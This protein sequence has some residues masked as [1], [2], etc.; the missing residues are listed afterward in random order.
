MMGAVKSIS[1]YGRT[2]V[3]VLAL[4]LTL[5]A[6]LLARTSDAAQAPEE[7]VDEIL[8]RARDAATHDRHREAIDFYR[9]A[10]ERDS[11]LR[12]V[13]SLELGHQYTW[14]EVPDSAIAWYEV[15]LAYNPGDIDARLGIARA[16][17]WAD[18][19]PE[20]EA[21]YRALLPEAGERKNEV[22]LGVAKVRAW[23][24]DYGGA[25]EVYREILD[26]DTGNADARLGLAQTLCW[27][28]RHR[29]AEAM[30][31]AILESDPDNT[32]AVN[33]L[34]ETQVSIGRPDRAIQTLDGAVGRGVR[35]DD[36]D[37]TAAAI[38]RSR[39]L[40]GS[41]TVSYR[42][43]SDDGENRTAGTS[44]TWPLGYL[45][46]LGFAYSRTR[47]HKAGYPDIDRDQ[48]S[49]SLARRLSDDVGVTAS[50]GYQLNRFDP[51]VVSPGLVPVDG[52]NLFI[53][54]AYVTVLPRDWVRIDAGTSREAMD[55]PLPVFKHIRVTTE[56]V[57]LDWRLRHRLIT[58]W[59]TRYSDYSDGNTRFAFSERAEW[60][61]PLRVRKRPN[62][63]FG[64]IQGVEHSRFGKQL[65]NGYFC[66]RVYTYAY[67][68]VRF[69][70]DLGKRFNVSLDGRLGGEKENGNDW[71]SVGA[72][73]G[74]LRLRVG[75][76][77]VLTGGY[78]KSGSR[79]DSP[80]GFRAEGFFMTLDYG[81]AP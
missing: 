81:G 24:E 29:E 77:V 10:V 13:V 4:V 22:L 76:R 66:P 72:F 25:E 73:E 47:L 46:E 74:V 60:T 3:V 8:Y 43:N 51:I 65:D 21:Y 30:F 53:W 16:T 35:N 11:T 36:L 67:G 49:L 7:S 23:Q 27:S 62:N 33:G 44:L 75:D 15:Y 79:L 14:A 78:F 38:R 34:A 69:V 80:D 31:G 48:F 19:L 42:K 6:G 18:R 71:A 20:A 1:T 63:R 52:F 68:G 41:T 61:P 64:L 17:S 56:N 50:P 32:E 28:G 9:R 59:E 37:K 40:R 5:A 55:I 54:D 26:A 2:E 70:T 45:T 12:S 57:G 58:F 39:D